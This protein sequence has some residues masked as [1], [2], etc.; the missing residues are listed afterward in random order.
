MSVA[1]LLKYPKTGRESRLV[2]ISTEEAFEV[3]WLPAARLLGLRW[4]P[5]FQAGVPISKS[6]VPSILTELEALREFMTKQPHAQLPAA[7]AAHVVERI[8]GLNFELKAMQE[9]ANI[10]AFIG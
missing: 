1:L 8:D 2:P 10:E 4:L 3:Y 5:L 7:V 6:D 9:I